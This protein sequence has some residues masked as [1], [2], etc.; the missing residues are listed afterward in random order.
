MKR[1][2]GIINGNRRTIVLMAALLAIAAL[3]SPSQ[4][5]APALQGFERIARLEGSWSGSNSHGQP[6]ELS[7]EVVADGSAVLEHLIITREKKTEKMVTLYHLDGD[8]LMLT[9]YCTAGNQPR[10]AAKQVSPNSIGFE[11]LDATG[12]PSLETGHMH[13]AKLSFE[14]DERLKAE[15]TWSE[16]GEEPF[17]AVVE[18]ERVGERVAKR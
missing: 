12:L 4:G 14:G 1:S 13:R 8:R 11:F 6:V 9:H 16:N 18:V 3:S 5:A 10:M 7:Y 2:D 15:W 17:T